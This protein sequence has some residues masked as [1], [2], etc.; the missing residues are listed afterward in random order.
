MLSTF[1]LCEKKGEWTI[2]WIFADAKEKN[3]M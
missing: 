2:E 1:V 3:A